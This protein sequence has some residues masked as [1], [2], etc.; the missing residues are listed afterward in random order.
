[1]ASY[2][3][4]KLLNGSWSEGNSFQV[5]VT[6]QEVIDMLCTLNANKAVGPDIIKTKIIEW[7]ME[8]R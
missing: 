5:I 8:W 7:I 3:K 6:E 4:L 1:V 2:A